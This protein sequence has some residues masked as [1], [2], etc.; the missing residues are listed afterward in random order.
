MIYPISFSRY[1]DIREKQREILAPKMPNSSIQLFT[2]I[3]AIFI[4][5]VPQVTQHS[6]KMGIYS[7]DSGSH[8]MLGFPPDMPFSQVPVIH[9]LSQFISKSPTHKILQVRI[10]LPL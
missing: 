2:C 4:H 5:T 10:N 7:S 9:P 3:F 6:M 8:L 1:V